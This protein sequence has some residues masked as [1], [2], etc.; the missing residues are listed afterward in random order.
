MGGNPF[1]YKVPTGQVVEVL[2]AA[3]RCERVKSFTWA[4]CQAAM[5]RACLQA[6][7]YQAIQRR[8]RQLERERLGTVA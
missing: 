2:N 4:E 1:E 7:V 5:K 8:L 6:T 3:D